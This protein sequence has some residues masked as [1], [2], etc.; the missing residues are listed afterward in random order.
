MIDFLQEECR[1]ADICLV[2]RNINLDT[3][4]MPK[5]LIG[6]AQLFK[7]CFELH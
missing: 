5:K 4:L 2:L 7:T 3:E 6:L 1:S